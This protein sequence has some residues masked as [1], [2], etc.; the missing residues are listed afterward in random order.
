[1]APSFATLSETDKNQMINQ[2][3]ESVSY[4]WFRNFVRFKPEDYVKKVQCPVLVLNG[5]NDLQVPPKSHM[6]GIKNAL[7]K[8][9]N[10]KVTLK[11]YP[12]LNHLFQESVTG[13]TEEYGAIEQ[14][15]S[16]NVLT[17]IKDWILVQT[18]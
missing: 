17:D 14:T 10:K 8:A 4:P 13:S 16:P 12:K 11:E 9:G 2:Q 18:N 1:K 5:E 6:T 15:F 7:D 3:I